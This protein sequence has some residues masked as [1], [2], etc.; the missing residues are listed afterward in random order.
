MKCSDL[1]A[2]RARCKRGIPIARLFRHYFCEGD[3]K[4]CPLKKPDKT[5]RG[6]FRCRRIS[7]LSTVGS[8]A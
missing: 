5:G 1:S 8:G 2:D 4:R 3:Y 6:P 7:N